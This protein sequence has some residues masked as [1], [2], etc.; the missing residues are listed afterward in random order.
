MNTT[1]IIQ[2][3]KSTTK[4]INQLKNSS[5][6][7]ELLDKKQERELIEKYRNNRSKL[8]ELLY[9]HNIRLAFNMAKKYATKTKDFD[10]LVSD[11]LYGLS[12]ACQRF[13]IDRG[14]KFSTYATPWIFKYCLSGFYDK[15]NLIDNASI[16]INQPIGTNLK[17]NNG[18]EV[19]FENYINEYMDLS[20]SSI[21]TVDQELS[22]FE[23]SDIYNN[24]MEEL[25]NDQSL[26]AVDKQVF[27]D[28][29]INKEKVKDIASKYNILANDVVK[30]KNKILYKFKD[31]LNTKYHINKFDQI[32]C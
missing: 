20:V 26:S 30:I 18:N 23:L 28:N 11:C 10:A 22:A 9:L 2:N 17:S 1:G 24:L 25:N 4:L 5:T 14:I 29:V 12:I 32:Y 21:K 31:L 27:I 3:N 19:T 16:S 8:N 15:Q 13:D 7:Y 6:Q